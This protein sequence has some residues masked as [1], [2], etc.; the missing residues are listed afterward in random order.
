MPE[1][2]LLRERLCPIVSIMQRGLTS[3]ARKAWLGQGRWGPLQ[4]EVAFGA[5]PPAQQPGSQV[6]RPLSHRD[7]EDRAQALTCPS[8]GLLLLK[9]EPPSPSFLPGPRRR[10]KEARLHPSRSL[11]AQQLRQV[12]SVESSALS[13]PRSSLCKGGLEASWVLDPDSAWVPRGQTG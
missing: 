3:A 9:S 2:G 13:A 10:P 5:Y 6:M 4:R 11:L 12:S 1:V 7:H 8:C